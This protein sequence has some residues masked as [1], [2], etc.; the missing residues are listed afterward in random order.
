MGCVKLFDPLF[1]SDPF[2]I[3]TWTEW[4]AD[5][6]LSSFLTM[7]TIAGL[8]IGLLFWFIGEELYKNFK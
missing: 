1:R 4:Y 7:T 6:H 3:A 5:L 8:G 2:A